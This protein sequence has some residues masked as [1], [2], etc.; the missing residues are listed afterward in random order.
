MCTKIMLQRSDLLQ[1][2]K[3]MRYKRSDIHVYNY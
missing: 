2:Q 1:L 3:E